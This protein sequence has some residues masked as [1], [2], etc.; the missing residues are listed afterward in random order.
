MSNSRRA[1][2]AA[3]ARAAK[4]QRASFGGSYHDRAVDEEDYEVVYSWESHLNS[5][6][7]HVETPRSPQK[8]RTAWVEGET[9]MPEDSPEFG[10]D[11]AGDWCDEEFGKDVMEPPRPVEKPVE[12]KKRSRVSVR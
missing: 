3:E 1:N 6:R 9:W 5:R 2:K 10:L 12:K 7:K 8:G 11:P 4:R